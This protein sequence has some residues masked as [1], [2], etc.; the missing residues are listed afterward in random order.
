MNYYIKLLALDLDGTTLKSNNTLSQTVKRAIERAHNSGIVIVAASG[1]PYGSLPD[2]ILNM[3]AFE[4]FIT[5][6]GAGIYD[7]RGKRIKSV[8]LKE[9]SVL[10]ILNLTKDYDLIWEAFLDGETCTD[11]RY[12]DN[13]QKYGCSAAYVDYVRNSR[14]YTDDMRGYIYKN[15]NRLDS[16]EF[17]STDDE[18][19]NFIW[20]KIDKSDFGVYVTSSSAHFVEI[21]DSMA[22]KA[23]ALR[24][25]CD[26]L[27]ISLKNTAAA[28]NADND[29]DMIVE[30]GLGVAVKNACC[31]CKACADLIV[32]SNDDD[33]IADL[34][35]ILL[36]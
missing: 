21:M 34:I 5:S 29:I 26:M 15:R 19:R 31:N 17:V 32:S 28:G 8:P 2:Y 35:D 36:K 27:N 30:S 7:N 1:R 23:N 14:G 16:I 25:I 33:G 20:N 9:K 4:Y 6:N 24:V 11:K 3:D 22:T 13:P 12:Y 18:L 10:D